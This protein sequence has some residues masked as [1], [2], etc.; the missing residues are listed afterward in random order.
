MVDFETRSRA[1]LKRLGGRRYAEHASTRI[2]CAVLRSPAGDAYDWTPGDCDPWQGDEPAEVLAHN[3]IGFD[4]HIWRLAGW[5]EPARWIDSAELARVAGFPLASLEWLGANLIGVEKDIE[6][7]ELT[8]KLSDPEL[9]YGDRLAAQLATTKV[10]WRAANK[11]RLPTAQLKSA[12]VE[13]FDRLH[14]PPAALP[15]ETLERVIRYCRLDVEIMFRLWDEVLHEWLDADLP[16][17]EQADRALNDRGVCFDRELAQIL[18]EASEELGRVACAAAGV[19]PAVVRSTQQLTVELAARGVTVFDCT[20]DTL[21]AAKAGASPAAVALIE[22][23]QATASIAVGKLE[24]G[25]ERCSA[26]GRL[27]DNRTYY[28]AHTGRWAG[29][30]AQ[31]DNLAKGI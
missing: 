1:D 19:T 20:A 8:K 27:R 28:G 22:A 29:K 31:L 6:G 14:A 23:R 12:V 15:P 18:I 2:V 26:D 25:L 5:P 9:Y 17:L 30:G 13:R 7:N 4:R 21:A 3:A 24:A 16:G 10:D 11:G